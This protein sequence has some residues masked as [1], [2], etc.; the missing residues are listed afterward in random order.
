MFYPKVLARHLAGLSVDARERFLA[1]CA[2]YGAT[3]GTPALATKRLNPDSIRHST[4]THFLRGGV[5]INT[6]RGWL[7]DVSLATTNVYAEID[8]EMKG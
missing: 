5:D 7:G 6:I 3:P 2:G 1:H 8:L 4:A